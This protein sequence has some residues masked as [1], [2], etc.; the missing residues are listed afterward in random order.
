MAKILICGDVTKNETYTEFFE[1]G[2][3]IFT[4][5]L[6]DLYYSF[7]KRIINL[8]SPI[9]EGL[10]PQKK[11]GAN[12]TFALT[13]LTGIKKLDA[14]CSISNNHALDYGVKG[15]NQTKKVLEENKIDFLGSKMREFIMIDDKVGVYSFCENEFSIKNA[16]DYLSIL[17]LLEVKDKVRKYKK[18]CKKLIVLYHGGKEFY[19]YPT[20]NNQKVCRAIADS[21]ADLVV[22]QHSHAVGCFEKYN[23]S[24]I[25]YGQGN[26]ISDY[27]SNEYLKNGMMISLDTKTDEIKFYFTAKGEKIDLTSYGEFYARSD[28]ITYSGF[29]EKEFKEYCENN[30]FG[31]YDALTQYG[32]GFKIINKLTKNKKLEKDFKRKKTAFRNFISTDT[33]KEI[34]EEILGET[35][36]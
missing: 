5:A 2:K 8:E 22:M 35:D 28:E 23:G 20:P 29:I 14:I 33:H 11:Y 21:G 31:Y 18:Q 4:P 25:V 16:C 30:K 9:T 3:D 27:T 19:P 34:L 17:D 6:L 13:D 12:F 32:K 24:T 15:L 26:F 1:R 7:D 10:K 36:E